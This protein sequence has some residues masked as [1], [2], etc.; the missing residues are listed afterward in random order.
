MNTNNPHPDDPYRGRYGGD[1]GNTGDERQSGQ[2]WQHPGQAQGGERRDPFE[3]SLAETWDAPDA[4][5]DRRLRAVV[6][7]VT[8]LNPPP[9]SFERVVLR[10]RRRRHRTAFIAAAASVVAVAVVAGGV[11]AGTRLSSSSPVEVAGCDSVGQSVPGAV[12]GVDQPVNVANAAD[13]VAV[14]DARGGPSGI[15][16]GREVMDRKYE[17]AIGGVLTA[18]ALSVGIVAGCSSSANN[19]GPSA[20]GTQSGAPAPGQSSAGTAS[21]PAPSSGSPAASSGSTGAAGVPRCHTADLSPAVSIVQG[22]QGAGQESMNIKLTN[23]SGHPCTVY[24]YPGMKLED[25]NGS[26][27]AT[28]VVWT[29]STK[30]S[31]TVANGA[32]VATTA[33][34]DFD[35]PAQDEPQTG[36]CEAPSVYLEITPPDET[37]QLSATIAGGPIT[38]CNHG[39]IEVLPFIAGGTGP[40]Q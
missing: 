15:G 12:R 3:D 34:F 22:S 26:G 6:G 10:A 32:S 27:Q 7:P 13:V 5:V 17:W 14:A 25:G 8:P 30:S 28:N 19:N 29:P 24:G 20:N 16:A 35:M 33:H 37:T 21:T 18:A 4:S 38:V 31:I 11:L 39:T 36:N 9:Y 1:S 23:T 2:S 40:N